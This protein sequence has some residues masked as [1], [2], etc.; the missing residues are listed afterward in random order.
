M[1]TA[2]GGAVGAG[3]DG[4]GAPLY[5]EPTAATV[6]L[7][8]DHPLWRG[9][10]PGFALEIRRRLSGHDLVLALGLPVFRLFGDSPGSALA[11]D[12]RLIHVDV[13]PAEIGRSHRPAVGMVADPRA[14]AEGVLAA[15][16]EPDPAARE[17]RGAAVAAAA[18]G[19]RSV[20]AHAL[21]AAAADSSR[22]TPEAFCLA[23]A[24]ALA[25]RDLLVDEALTSTRSLRSLVARR[26]PATWL[27][28]RGS[29]LG[30]GLPAA[31]G[32]ALADRRRRVMCLQGDGG[33][34]FGIHALWTAAHHRARVALV[35]ADNGGYEILRAGLEG[36]T[37]RAQDAWPGIAIAD[38]RLDIAA[39]CRGFGVDAQR[40]ERR[41]ELR[42]AFVDLWQRT[43]EGPAA[44]IVS[45]GGRTAPV[46]YP[47]TPS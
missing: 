32:A 12:V 20:R 1:G 15:L 44:L 35:V 38:P 24:D 10:L 4:L 19:R 11:D 7:P 26:T 43:R 31:V 18:T 5:G 25:P 37:G 2:A 8:T 36:L 13:D 28:H 9:Q 6:P 40:V 21:R 30:W 41:R 29:A 3:A 16:G 22:I 34:L 17:R 23:V 46:G 42:E 27:A 39:L 45:V 33:L 47:L 14:V